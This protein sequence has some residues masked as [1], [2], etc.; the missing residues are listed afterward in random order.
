MVKT[1]FS[2]KLCNRFAVLEV[3]ENINIDCIQMEKVY[4][5]TAENVLG[6]AKKKNKQWLKEE[7]W[8][9]IDQRQMIHDKIRSMKSERRKG[10]L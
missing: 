3:E 6:Q 2:V 9:G 7:T 4:T 5:Q 10:K 8:K 1:R